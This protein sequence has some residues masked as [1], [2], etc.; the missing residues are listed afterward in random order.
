MFKAHVHNIRQVNS[1]LL[2]L[3]ISYIFLDAILGLVKCKAGFV[4]YR[5]L[6]KETERQISPGS[7]TNE[8]LNWSLWIHPTRSMTQWIISVHKQNIFTLRMIWMMLEFFCGQL[9]SYVVHSALRMLVL[10]WQFLEGASG[11]SKKKTYTW[12]IITYFLL[13]EF[14]YCFKK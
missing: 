11:K 5:L 4:K 8:V 2:S 7:L 10:H 3:L 14:K 6:R 12:D 9:A 13:M 1:C